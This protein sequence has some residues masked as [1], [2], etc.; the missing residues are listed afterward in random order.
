M[1]YIHQTTTRP[2]KPRE[3]ETLSAEIDP[4]VD[5]PLDFYPLPRGTRG[6]RFPTNDP[7][8][9]SVLEPRPEGRREYLHGL[10]QAIARFV[11]VA[12]GGLG[13]G[14]EHTSIHLYALLSIEEVCSRS[15]IRC[16]KRELSMDSFAHVSVV[17]LFGDFFLQRVSSPRPPPPPS[18][19]WKVGLGISPIDIV[20]GLSFIFMVYHHSHERNAFLFLNTNP[21][22][23]IF[24][25]SKGWREMD[26]RRWK[27]SE[28]RSLQG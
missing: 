3:L 7:L 1:A 8:K 27:R 11:C 4:S 16:F 6:E 23:T 22:R 20:G 18:L 5:S 28:R 25:W 19:Q 9:E 21:F 17:G 24:C 14:S 13:R 10:L 12:G 2:K 15:S 26:T